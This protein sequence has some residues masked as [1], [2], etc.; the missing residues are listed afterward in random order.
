[1]R[2]SDVEICNGAIGLCG[3][4]D[5]IQSLSDASQVSARRCKQFFLPA[6]ERV[7][8]KHGWNC[9]TAIQKLAE[10]TA[11][12][13]IEYANAFALP[14]DCV[15]VIDVYGSAD[16]YSPYDRWRIVGRN[17]HTELDTVYLKYIRFPEDFR[18]LDILLAGAIEYEMALRL[19]PTLIKDKEVYGILF[20]AAQQA[21]REAKAMDTLENKELYVENDGWSDA[22]ES[23]GG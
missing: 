22:R 18:E 16:C 9:A 4:T 2:M 19:A 1:M 5:F 3:S 11:A 7:L 10:N 15:K 6:V 21:L 17:I 8:R 13:T 14:H 23:V 20:Q 12:P